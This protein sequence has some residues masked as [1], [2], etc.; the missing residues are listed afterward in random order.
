MFARISA[1]VYVHVCLYVSTHARPSVH[2]SQ[3]SLCTCGQLREHDCTLIP[4]SIF[5]GC[6]QGNAVLV[7]ELARPDPSTSSQELAQ[8]AKD[9][10]AAGADAL[11]VRCDSS[12]TTSGLTDLFCVTQ[13]VGKQVRVRHVGYAVNLFLLP[14]PC[15]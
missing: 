10:I 6:L 11:A 13:A 2:L 1:C 3:V 14:L 12:D 4:P 8:L 5:Y 7:L 15:G 9:Y